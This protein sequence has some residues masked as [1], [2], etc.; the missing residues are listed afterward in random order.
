MAATHGRTNER[1]ET[2]AFLLPFLLL[3]LLQSRPSQS[4]SLTQARA[5][6]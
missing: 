3:L 6:P 1:A 2:P 4:Y 5:S